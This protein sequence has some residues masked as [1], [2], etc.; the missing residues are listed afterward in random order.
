MPWLESITFSREIAVLAAQV[1][2]VLVIA[3]IVEVRAIGERRR[4]EGKDSRLLIWMVFG[5]LALLLGTCFLYANGPSEIVGEKALL[6]WVAIVTLLGFQI[7]FVAMAAW[8]G[9]RVS[10]DEGDED[11]DRAERLDM[12]L[13]QPGWK[14]LL[15]GRR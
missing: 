7:V 1:A 8:A 13:R 5:S 10:S 11:K 12:H 3:F 2:P 14:W 6:A 15:R 4:I 9:L